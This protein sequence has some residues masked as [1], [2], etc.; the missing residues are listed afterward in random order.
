MNVCRAIPLFKMLRK[1]FTRRKAIWRRRKHLIMAIRQ[2]RPSEVYLETTSACNLNCVMC[3]TQR[4]SV[5]AFKPDGYM[6]FRL[7]C[8][9]VDQIGEMTPAPRLWLHKDGEPLLHPRI[10]E[11][12]EYASVRVPHVVL[13]TNGTLLNGKMTAAILE[14]RLHEVRFSLEGSN[15]ETYS[16]VRRQTSNNPHR[17]AGNGVGYNKVVENIVR[18]CELKKAK[19]KETPRVGIQMVE[20]EPTRAE[21]DTAVPFWSEVADFVR[22]IPLFSWSGTV[23]VQKEMPPFRY[24][25]EHLWESQVISS[26]GTMVPCCIYVDKTG[27]MGGHLADLSSKS[28]MEAFVSPGISEIRIA[29]LLGNLDAFEFCAKCMDWDAGWTEPE[30]L[31]SKRFKR[32]ML[33]EINRSSCRFR[34]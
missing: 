33:K 12:I 4:A 26:D 18:F 32:R 20:F 3:P 14:T 19:G 10:V 28:M 17:I 2:Q 9:L 34:E 23:S 30:R 7:F 1:P 15:K 11:M 21:I 16:T 8:R 6:D 27:N 5:K 22:V 25:C 24:P 13:V 31:W 29:H